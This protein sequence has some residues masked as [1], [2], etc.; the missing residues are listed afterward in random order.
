M[1]K[2]GAAIAVLTLAASAAMAATAPFTEVIIDGKSV[3]NESMYAA[4]NGDLYFGSSGTGDVY[5]AKKGEA[6]ATLFIEAAKYGYKSGLGVYADYKTNTLYVCSVMPRGV[7]PAQPELS[8]LKL[9]D[10]RSGKLKIS[11]PIGAG[12]TCNDVD[13]DKKGDVYVAETNGGRVLILKKGTKG[14]LEEFVVDQRIRGIDGLAFID[15]GDLIVNT[16]TSSRMFSIKPDKTITELT[17]SLKL[18]GP[19]G[20]RSSG[21]NRVLQAE[22]GAGR[23]TEITINGDKAEMRVVKDGIPGTTG[24]GLVGDTVWINNGHIVGAKPP[25]EGPWQSLSTPLGR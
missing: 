23:I 15:N 8:A 18:R 14:G 17:P 4:P 2:L 21:G 10:L 3:L 16:V 19:D 25:P 1:L 9:F 6:K 11:Y 5:R 24:M 12:T 20:M 22:N 13:I 7:T